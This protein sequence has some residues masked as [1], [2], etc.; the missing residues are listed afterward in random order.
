MLTHGTIKEAEDNPS[1][2]KP[3]KQTIANVATGTLVAAAVIVTTFI[4]ADH[5]ETQRAKL[6]CRKLQ[7]QARI[8]KEQGF[9]ITP[10][11]KLQCDYYDMH[12]D[13]PVTQRPLFKN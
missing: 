2:S 13:A 4:L 12:I 9:F 6:E 5:A 10:G 11:E 7:D 8:Y 1:A 3:M